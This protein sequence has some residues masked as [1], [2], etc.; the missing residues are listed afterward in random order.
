MFLFVLHGI[1]L[2][3]TH[4]EVAALRS[5][6]DGLRRRIEQCEEAAE[7]ARCPLCMDEVRPGDVV[8]FTLCAHMLIC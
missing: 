3:R 7:A 8:W 1:A 5:E 2:P 4:N 6:R